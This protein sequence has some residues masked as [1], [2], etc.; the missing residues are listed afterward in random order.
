MSF[1][2]LSAGP[3]IELSYLDSGTPSSSASVYT[4]IVAIH[5]MCFSNLIFERILPI[6]CNKG[7]RFVAPNRRQYPGST[8][9]S[10]EELDIVLTGATDVV[11]ESQL[12][13]RGMEMGRF[14]DELILTSG[15]PPIS[16]D[17]KSGGIILLGWSLGSALALATLASAHNLPAETQVRLG[18]YIR[19]VILYDPAPIILGLPTPEQNWTPFL[20]TYIPEHL[21]LA[22]FAQWSTGYFD[23]GDLKKRDP[24]ALSWVLPAPHQVPTVFLPR[25]KRTLC[26]A[27][28]MGL[29]ISLTYMIHF[30]GQSKAAYRKVINDPET[31]KLFPNLKPVLLVGGCSG[32]FAIARL[33]A[34]ED[35]QKEMGSSSSSLTIR[36]VQGI[37]HM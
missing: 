21:R 35:D 33:W 15:L 25:I 27:D 19:S 18:S 22:A 36:F 3:G 32:A 30:V 23:H 1:K 17:K 12:Q 13:Q 31:F 4:T 5:G 34:V 11:K 16:A 14:I 28:S 37:N 20:D 7:A 9:Y 6:A 26:A 24:G 29:V 8:P 10:S 2:T